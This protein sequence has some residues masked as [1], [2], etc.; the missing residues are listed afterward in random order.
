L[1]F[2]VGQLLNWDLAEDSAEGFTYIRIYTGQYADKLDQLAFQEVL[3]RKVTKRR[4]Q[5]CGKKSRKS[6]V[7]GQSRERRIEAIRSPRV[8]DVTELQELVSMMSSS[9][10]TLQ[11]RL[12]KSPGDY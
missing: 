8:M 1:N 4:Q 12:S 5:R 10:Q 11:K 7:R 3:A 2:F 9:L 6:D